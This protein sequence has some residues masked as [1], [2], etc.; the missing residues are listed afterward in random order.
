MVSD[1]SAKAQG[2]LGHATRLAI[3]LASADG[4]IASVAMQ[5]TALGRPSST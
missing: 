5:A 3:H 2:I 1:V 4:W